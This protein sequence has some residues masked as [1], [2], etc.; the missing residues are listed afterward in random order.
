PHA[1]A[2]AASHARAQAP[3]ERVLPQVG[4]EAPPRL[5]SESSRDASVPAV[6]S[7][8]ATGVPVAS[9]ASAPVA[10]STA[11]AA[12]AAP[13]YAPPSFGASY[14]HNPK[15][16]YPLMAR[17]RGLQGLVRLDVKVNADGIPTAVRVKDSSGHEAL[18]EAALTAVWHW[19]FAPA[20]RGGEAVEGSVVVPVRFNLD[21][22][23]AS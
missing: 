4:S 9:A 19:R 5:T 14:L 22:E 11:G 21:G 23:A 15:P 13:A 12:G 1:P 2:P 17:R 10:V 3:A 8:S 6:A 18:D 7:G 20:R 16:S